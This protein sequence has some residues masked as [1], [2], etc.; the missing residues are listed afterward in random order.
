MMTFSQEKEDVNPLSG[1]GCGTSTGRD[2]CTAAV[3]FVVSGAAGPRT[4]TET[5]NP[6]DSSPLVSPLA[7]QVTRTSLMFAVAILQPRRMKPPRRSLSMHHSATLPRA[8]LIPSGFAPSAIWST[9]TGPPSPRSKWAPLKIRQRS[10]VG[11]P[12]P[13]GYGNPASSSPRT[14]HSH[15]TSEGSCPPTHLQKSWASSGDTFATGSLL[16][17]GSSFCGAAHFREAVSHRVP[18]LSWPTAL[19][20]FWY[21]AFVVS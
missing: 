1:E 20:N 13:Q 9:G 5:R 6:D 2:G 12:L 16:L 18:A 4:G 7:R 19:K 3:D 14:A 8:C 15:S 10:F 11:S 21:C 17:T